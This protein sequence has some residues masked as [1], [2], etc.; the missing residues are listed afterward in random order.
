MSPPACCA[1]PA[2]ELWEKLQKHLRAAAKA[3]KAG[4]WRAALGELFGL[5]LFH[6]QHDQHLYDNELYCDEEDAGAIPKWF[7]K[8]S[9]CWRAVLAR[10]DDELGLAPRGGAPGGSRGRLLRLLARWQLR[11]NKALEGA[12]YEDAA[13]DVLTPAQAA[14]L[15]AP[16]HGDDDSDEQ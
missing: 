16:A 6:N 2:Q 1:M 11:M 10:G 3:V 4:R 5:V 7:A 13:V 8:L 15:A 14:S 12:D 9:A